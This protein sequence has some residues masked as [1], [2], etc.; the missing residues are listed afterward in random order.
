MRLS[1]A[2]FALLKALSLKGEL[3]ASAVEAHAKPPTRAE[4][5][6]IN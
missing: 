4:N 1:S 6:M 3:A 2:G 5:F